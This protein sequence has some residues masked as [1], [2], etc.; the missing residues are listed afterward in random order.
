[1][2]ERNG[3]LEDNLFGFRSAHLLIDIY[4]PEQMNLIG[5]TDKNEDQ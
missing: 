2:N 3:F 5:R 1:M 4:K